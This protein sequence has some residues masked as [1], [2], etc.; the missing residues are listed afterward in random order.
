MKNLDFCDIVQA[1]HYPFGKALLLFW[2]KL[3]FPE[4][5]SVL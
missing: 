3:T 1:L 2:D 5:P 4:D